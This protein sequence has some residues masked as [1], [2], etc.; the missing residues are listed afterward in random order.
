MVVRIHFAL[1]D[2]VAERLATLATA[3]NMSRQ[4]F[5]QGLIMGVTPAVDAVAASS[6]KVEINRRARNP[7]PRGGEFSKDDQVGKAKR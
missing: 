2:E 5:L 4:A 1:R 3:A 6:S 7:E